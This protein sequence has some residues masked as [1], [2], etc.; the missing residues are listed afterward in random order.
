M[1]ELIPE[2][3]ITP[4][5]PILKEM[6][7][8]RILDIGYYS[9]YVLPNGIIRNVGANT[10]EKSKFKIIEFYD[11]YDFELSTCFSYYF[12]SSVEG[13][14]VIVLEKNHVGFI[15]LSDAIPT[16]EVNTNLTME[17]MKELEPGFGYFFHSATQ[18]PDMSN[19]IVNEMIGTRILAIDLIRV[20]YLESYHDTSNRYCI[21][22]LYL[23][24][25]VERL[26]GTFFED[27][28][29]IEIRKVDN[30]DPKRIEEVF[31]IRK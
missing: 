19:E 4:N 7:G 30:I 1:T 8:Q 20:T 27:D 10:R 23:E 11:K 18:D 25:G 29:V 2:Y 17:R 26:F 31:E 21:L 28:R 9:N 14:L 16:L 5:A 3:A 12:G 13:A 22:K 24:N 6:I 15:S